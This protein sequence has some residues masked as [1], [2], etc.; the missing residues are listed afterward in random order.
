MK[1]ITPTIAGLLMGLILLS[2]CTLTG[3]NGK[4][5]MEKAPVMEQ[6]L[7]AEELGKLKKAYF[8]SGCF[9]CV[10][11]IFESVIGVKE[12]VSGYA[13][14]E[15]DNPSY[16]QVA[17]GQTRHAE[18]VEVYYDPELVSYET[19]LLV[20]FDSHDPTT[21]NRQGPDRGPQYRSAIYYIGET[22]KNLVEAYI[23]KLKDEKAFDGEITTEV[24]PFTK[25]WKAEEYHQDFERKNPNQ[26]Y[27]RAVSIPRLNKFKAKHPELLKKEH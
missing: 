16:R 14:G 10:E 8:A 15:I 26:P 6:K 13:G 7:S 25:F 1:Y 4:D 23:Q 12:V 20:F 22:E 9:W 27:V 18:A 3:K 11:A 19:L 24:S 21:L 2:A 17:S 5:A